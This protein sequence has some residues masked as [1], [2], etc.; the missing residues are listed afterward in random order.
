MTAAKHAVIISVGTRGDVAP[1]TGVGARLRQAGHRVTVAADEAFRDGVLGA[2]LDFRPLPGDIRAWLRTTE[3]GSRSETVRAFRAYIRAVNLSVGE[4]ASDADIL[5]GT[6]WGVAAYHVAEARGIPSAGLHTAPVHPTGEFPP[7][8]VPRSLGRAGNRAAYRLIRLAE[9]MVFHGVNELRARYGLPATSV[10]AT[11]R[12]QD[13]ERWPVLHGFSSQVVPRPRDWR[14]GLDLTGYWW[15]VAEPGWTPPAELS[16]F[17][18]AGP[19]PVF[20]GFGSLPRDDADRLGRTVT[21]ALRRA[22]HRGVVQSG[23]AGLTGDGDDMITVGEVPHEWLFPRVAAAVHAAGAGTTAAALR[24]GLPSVP[25]PQ[26]GDQPFWAGRLAALGTAPTA[27]LRFRG[28]TEDKLADAVE[29]ATANPVYRER[30]GRLAAHLETED[31]AA[32]VL[33]TVERLL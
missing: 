6:L 31:G 33:E 21:A 19:P 12:R 2:G 16:R 1:C 22:G 30:A 14:A 32:R 15:P 20:V 5:L 26:V 8:A 10:T 29:E 25:L 3:S 27:S 28:L 13:R 4:I 9:R 23:W 18:D 24:A 11:Y 7:L 17:L